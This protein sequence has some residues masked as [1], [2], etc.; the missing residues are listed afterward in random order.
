[1]T[2]SGSAVDRE[3]LDIRL[4]ADTVAHLMGDGLVL[5]SQAERGKRVENR[6]VLTKSDLITLLDAA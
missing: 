6:V 1:M 4:D 2:T 3:G 5:V